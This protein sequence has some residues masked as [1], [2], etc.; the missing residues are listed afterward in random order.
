[1]LDKVGMVMRCIQEERRQKQTHQM[2][3]FLCSIEVFESSQV[4][5]QINKASPFG[6]YHGMS[7][8]QMRDMAGPQSFYK[9]TEM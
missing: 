1:M 5:L 3:Q 4:S 9:I 6:G 8:D 2:S 7:G